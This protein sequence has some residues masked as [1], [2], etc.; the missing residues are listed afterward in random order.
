MNPL[1]SLGY[2]NPKEIPKTTKVL[3]LKLRVQKMLKGSDR[4][5]IIT[6]HYHAIHI[7]E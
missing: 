4:S 5:G 2:L 6:S 1:G 3:K 7:D